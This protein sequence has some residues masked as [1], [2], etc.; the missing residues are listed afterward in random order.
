MRKNSIPNTETMLSHP[1]IPMVCP[2][3][4]SEIN[5]EKT[6]RVVIMIVNT[7]APNSLMV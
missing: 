2:N 3:S 4:T 7:T 1:T 6:W 5:S